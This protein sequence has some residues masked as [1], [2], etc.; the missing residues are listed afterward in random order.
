[1]PKK[2]G[3]IRTSKATLTRA[4]KRIAKI[5]KAPQKALN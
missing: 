3:K 2:A 4:V 1:M 5:D